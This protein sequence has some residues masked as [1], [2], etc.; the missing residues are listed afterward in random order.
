[1]WLILCSSYFPHVGVFVCVR[2]CIF[3]TSGSVIWRFLFIQ[4]FFCCQVVQLK[5]NLTAS[6]IQTKIQDDGGAV[7]KYP[8]SKPYTQWMIEGEIV[9]C[10]SATSW[11]F[12]AFCWIMGRLMITCDLPRVSER[13]IWPRARKHF[14]KL[15]KLCIQKKH[16][17]ALQ[18]SVRLSAETSL[19]SK[20]PTMPNDLFTQKL[21]KH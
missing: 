16:I 5:G 1:M 3:R 15:A 17:P 13:H 19:N 7:L 14:S 6:K 18:I 4:M 20:F 21:S 8:E 2:K 9:M 10:N 12:P 11:C